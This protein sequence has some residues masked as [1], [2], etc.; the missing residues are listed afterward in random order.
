[1]ANL[2][3]LARSIK[4]IKRRFPANGKRYSTFVENPFESGYWPLV[5]PKKV[6]LAALRRFQKKRAA[7]R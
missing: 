5:K 6:D 3:K 7:A 4:E 1:M 2:K